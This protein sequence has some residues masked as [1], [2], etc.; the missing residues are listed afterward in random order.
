MPAAVSQGMPTIIAALVTL[1]DELAKAKQRKE[2]EDAE[3]EE[4]EDD[5]D[6]DGVLDVADDEDEDGEG[7]EDIDAVLRKIA[8]LKVPLPLSSF[9]PRSLTLPPLPSCTRTPSYQ[10][11]RFHCFFRVLSCSFRVLSCA[12]F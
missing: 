2:E 5:D 8:M 1:E 6:D 11:W 9:L 12:A 7:E 3:E 10:V 4:E